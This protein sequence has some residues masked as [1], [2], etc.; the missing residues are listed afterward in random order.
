M[1]LIKFNVAAP[2]KGEIKTNGGRKDDR[3]TTGAQMDNGK[4]INERWMKAELR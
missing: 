2:T 1:S 3:W 4:L